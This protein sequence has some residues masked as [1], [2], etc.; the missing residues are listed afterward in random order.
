MGAAEPSQYRDDVHA[1]AEYLIALP[2][3]TV[4]VER[5][6]QATKSAQLQI[7]QWQPS[8]TDS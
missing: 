2:P 5:L 8:K 4:L 3:R 1:I 6:Q 7:E